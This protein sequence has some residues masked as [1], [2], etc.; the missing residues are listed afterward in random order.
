MPAK[1]FSS[2]P[3]QRA[4][5]DPMR[6]VGVGAQAC[7]AVGFVFRIVAV[8]PDHFAVTLEGEDM[9]GDAAEVTYG[10]G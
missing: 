9:G 7:F 3:G 5:L 8:E 10:P 6:I 4:I 1:V 2:S